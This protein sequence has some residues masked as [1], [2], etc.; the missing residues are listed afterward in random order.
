MLGF[1]VCTEKYSSVVSY[2]PNEPH[3]LVKG[4]IC[5][6]DDVDESGIRRLSN[7]YLRENGFK[8]IGT[9]GMT[10]ASHKGDVYW[11]NYMST[12]NPFDY[13]GTERVEIVE[14]LLR[15]DQDV[16]VINGRNGEV[17]EYS[18]YIK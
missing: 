2:D 10:L 8:L 15:H 11:I 18:L 14:F 5:V 13:M 3:Y 12:H 4:G 6:P 9:L 7:R 1:D 17:R 16:R